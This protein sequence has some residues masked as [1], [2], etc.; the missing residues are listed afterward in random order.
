MFKATDAKFDALYGT[1][2]VH[3]FNGYSGTYFDDNTYGF[4]KTTMGLEGYCIQEVYNILTKSYWRRTKTSSAVSWSS[5]TRADNFGCNTLPELA[6]A[7]GGV[8]AMRYIETSEDMNQ[9]KEQGFYL[10]D[11]ARHPLNMPSFIA[12]QVSCKVLVFKFNNYSIIQMVF[13]LNGVFAYRIYHTD[14]SWYGWYQA[15]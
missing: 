14:G 12:S 5:F 7:L 11:S 13:S 8:Q 3:T 4:V 15:G 10:V 6:S 2:S 1:S 9:I